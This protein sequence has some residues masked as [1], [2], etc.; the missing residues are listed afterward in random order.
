M[1]TLWL[2][3]RLRLREMFSSFSRAPSKNGKKRSPLVIVLLALLMVYVAAVFMF[4]FFGLFVV[5]WMGLSEGGLDLAFYFGA[6]GLL[7][8]ALC[9]FGSVMTTQSALYHARDNELLLSMPIPP[10]LILLSRMVFLFVINTVFA[11]VVAVPAFVVYLLCGA[12]SLLSAIGFVVFFLLLSVLA[13]AISCLL[14]WLVALITSRMK[15]KNIFSLIF[16]L[17]FLVLYFAIMMS[18]GAGAEELEELD[19]TPLVT[20]LSPYLTVFTWIGNALLYGDLLSAGLFLLVFAAV[21]GLAALFLTRTYTRI[22]TTNRGGAQYTYREK[23]AK[24]SSATVALVKKEIAHFVGNATYMLNEGL[25]LLF[26]VG[27]SIYFL[28]SRETVF[29]V[30][31]ELE[32]SPAL[33]LVPSLAAGLL[34]LCS[35]MVIIS[36]PS[37]SLEGKNVW[38]AQS[39]PLHGGQVLCAKA[40]AHMVVATPFFLVSSILCAVASGAGILEALG[41]L[42]LP[43]ACNTFCAFL[44]VTFN[45]LLPKLD[46]IN[47]AY[48]VKSGAAVA[49]T[50][51]GM[52]AVSGLLI[53]AMA[54]LP[55][56]GLPGWGGMLLTS[57]VFLGLSAVLRAYLCG[58]GAKRFAAL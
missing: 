24:Q 1:K 36:A 54:V 26:A 18:L 6:A 20:A 30:L 11:A 31:E 51:F 56:T 53:V 45:I 55:L 40:Y 41:L 44:G 17:I 39:L 16:M 35:S 14:G 4:L 37:V 27:I 28:V 48:A 15:H 19:I 8:V 9:V 49:L 42:L 43:F 23:A 3:V 5:L 32:L 57:L 22:L 33:G 34:C 25:G 29:A 38:L 12:P 50:M 21:V 2:L 7:T 10:S 58:A 47:E 52:M 46:W 13:L